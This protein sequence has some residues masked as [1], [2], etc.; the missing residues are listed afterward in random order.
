MITLDIVSAALWAVGVALFV[1]LV[2]LLDAYL[3]ARRLSQGIGISIEE[4][5][6]TDAYLEHGRDQLRRTDK[7]RKWI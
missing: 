7:P 2:G 3:R 6:K 4:Y 5:V 1:A